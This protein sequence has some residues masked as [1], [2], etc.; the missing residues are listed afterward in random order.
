MTMLVHEKT[1][2]PLPERPSDA[3]KGTFGTVI[4]AGGCRTMIGAPALAAG[5]A[6]RAG[7]GLVKILTDAAIIPHV[8]GLEPCATAIET[9]M[10]IEQTLAN[11]NEADRQETAVLALGPGLGK[12][13]SAW[14]EVESLLACSRR[15]VIDADALN[16]LAQIRPGGITSLGPAQLVLTPHPGEF[17]RLADALGIKL[18]ATDPKERPEAAAALARAFNAV[19][20]LKGKNTIIADAKRYIVNPFANP[21]MATAGTG[22]VLTGLIAGLLA[23]HC[24]PWDAAVLGAHLHS[25]AAQRWSDVHGLSGMTAVDLMHQLPDTFHE[26]RLNQ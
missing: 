9:G 16:I 24:S 21:A 18:S 19:V 1:L 17:K 4:I 6:L 2:P 23:Q 14:R 5:A 26:H 11:L 8:L 7:A 15:M 13:P 20:L 10:S 3:H 22:D 25:K 12:D